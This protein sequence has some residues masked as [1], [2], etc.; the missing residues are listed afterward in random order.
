VCV[1][2]GAGVAA[3]RREVV[4]TKFYAVFRINSRPN[5]LL[6]CGVVRRL[7]E[8][9]PTSA[10]T[11]PSSG[12]RSPAPQHAGGGHTDVLIHDRSGAT[13][14]RVIEAGARVFA[15]QGFH[16][17]T[18]ERIGDAAGYSHQTVRD[19]F[20]TKEGLLGVIVADAWRAVL[21][22]MGS[23]SEATPIEQLLAAYDA[24]DALARA[25]PAEA[26]CVL[27]EAQTA[28]PRGAPLHIEEELGFKHAVEQIIGAATGLRGTAATTRAEVVVAAMEALARPNVVATDGELKIKYPPDDARQSFRTVA[29]SMLRPAVS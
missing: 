23:R 12:L 3:R 20:K 1:L 4:V 7:P 10:G 6:G 15:E 2:G 16:A 26:R 25:R 22:A 5:T 28:G 29:E 27:H 11:S 24:L 18:K 17:A 21:D 8:E 9:T 19:Y 14:R 13:R